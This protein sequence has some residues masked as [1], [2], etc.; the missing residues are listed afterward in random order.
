MASLGP[1]LPREQAL[2]MRAPRTWKGSTVTASSGVR[3]RVAPDGL[4]VFVDRRDEQE[5][6]K[7][8][9]KVVERPRAT[10]QIRWD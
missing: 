4:V 9:F 3:Y 7:R 6:A 1:P 10:A 8:G 5:L 2:Q